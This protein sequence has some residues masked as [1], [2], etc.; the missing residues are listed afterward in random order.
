MEDVDPETLIEFIDELKDPEEK[1]LAEEAYLA[2][3]GRLRRRYVR[4]KMFNRGLNK[5][6]NADLIE[7]FAVDI[8]TEFETFSVIPMIKEI[9]S[10][11]RQVD[12]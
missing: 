7:E 8:L 6:E 5:L 12:D 1:G 9:N 2:L 11:R 10:L 3:T 4:E